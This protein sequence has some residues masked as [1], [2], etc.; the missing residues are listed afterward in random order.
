L[1]FLN[2]TGTKMMEFHTLVHLKVSH[3]RFKLIFRD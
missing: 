2:A 1:R 3:K